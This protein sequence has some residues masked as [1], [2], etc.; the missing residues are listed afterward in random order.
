MD[1]YFS[2]KQGFKIV[3]QSHKKKVILFGFETVHPKANPCDK[4]P[5]VPIMYH[6]RLREHT[7]QTFSTT[8]DLF[9]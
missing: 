1:V 4:F 5:E 6:K 7:Q 3:V 2:F 9:F 8:L